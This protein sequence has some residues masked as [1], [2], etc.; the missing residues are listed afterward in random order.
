MTYRVIDIETVPLANSMEAPYPLAERQPPSNY[1]NAN[2]IDAWR[3]RDRETWAQERAKVCSLSP[4]LGRVLCVG[5]AS[6]DGG[7]VHYGR[8]EGDERE[9]LRVFW[10]NMMYHTGI[11]D[12]MFN[13]T[14]KAVTWNGGWDLRFLL[15]R[16]L[17]NG[18]VPSVPAHVLQNWAK[19]YNTEWHTDVKRVLVGDSIT[20]GEGLD[21]WATA[22]G[23]PGKTGGWTGASVYPAYLEGRHGDIQDYCQQDVTATL[24]LYCKIAHLVED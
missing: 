5:I 18:V 6:R 12:R 2:A 10:A 17:L 14:Y 4:R 21:E 7:I 24:A 3:E 13:L 9:V 1:R 23:L 16:S 19:P 15:V 8:D 20:K 22:F 11:H